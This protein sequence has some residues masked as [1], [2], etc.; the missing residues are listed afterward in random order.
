VVVDASALQAN[1]ASDRQHTWKA[2]TEDVLIVADH[3]GQTWLR[4]AERVVDARDD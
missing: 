2:E 3:A 4:C 1:V